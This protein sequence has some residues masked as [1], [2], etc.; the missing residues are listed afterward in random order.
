VP[1]FSDAYPDYFDI[2]NNIIPLFRRDKFG[3]MYE[4]Q[5]SSHPPKSTSWYA[6]FNVILALGCLLS[7]EDDTSATTECS[8]VASIDAV[9]YLRN[10]WSVFTELSL[11]CR[12]IMTVQALLAMVSLPLK[13]SLGPK[14]TIALLVSRHG[15]PP[16]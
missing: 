12:D 11:H 10:S 16:R 14:L 2:F 15:S 3:K 7:H 5:Y 4:Q 13:L 8:M 9:D 6:S 1:T